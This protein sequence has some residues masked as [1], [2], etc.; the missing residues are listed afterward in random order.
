[1]TV[2]EILDI[3]AVHEAAGHKKTAICN[4]ALRQ[5]VRVSMSGD[6]HDHRRITRPDP[7]TLEA[8]QM[9]IAGND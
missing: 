5:L 7:G 4:V 2:S 6:T 8:L 1:M 9:A 3:I